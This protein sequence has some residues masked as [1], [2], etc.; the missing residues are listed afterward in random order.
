[1]YKDTFG[2]QVHAADGGEVLVSRVIPKAVSSSAAFNCRL[3]Y[4]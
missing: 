4:T 1:M 3:N 2:T